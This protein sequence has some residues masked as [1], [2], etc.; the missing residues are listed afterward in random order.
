M[1]NKK[2]SKTEK[3]AEAKVTH[4]PAHPST[5]AKEEFEVEWEAIQQLEKNVDQQHVNEL[6]DHVF[7]SVLSKFGWTR[8]EQGHLE[9]TG[10]EEAA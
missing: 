2:R 4:A 6:T 5:R 1:T 3:K 7:S 10:M 8:N 9:N